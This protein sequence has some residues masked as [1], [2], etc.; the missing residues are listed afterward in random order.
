VGEGGGEGRTPQPTSLAP[1]VTPEEAAKLKA[2]K[3]PEVIDNKQT[4]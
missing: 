2:A 3:I 4:A 1:I